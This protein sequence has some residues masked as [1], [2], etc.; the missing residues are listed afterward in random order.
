VLHAVAGTSYDFRFVLTNTTTQA[1]GFDH[2]YYLTFLDLDGE[3][4]PDGTGIDKAF[5]EGVGVV[6]ATEAI[7]YPSGGSVE[8]IVTGVS[9]PSGAYYGLRNVTQ[10]VT[11]DFDVNAINTDIPSGWYSGVVGFKV[12]LQGASNKAPS[13]LTVI[14][15]GKHGGD[16]VHDG[17]FCFAPVFPRPGLGCP[18]PA[19]PAQ[20]LASPPSPPAQP[21]GTLPPPSPPPPLPSPPPPTAPLPSPP[22][23]LPS[24]PPPSLPLPSP[25][26]PLPSPPPPT[27]APPLDPPPVPSTPALASPSPLAPPFA[28]GLAP[29]Y[30]PCGEAVVTMDLAEVTNP[31]IYMDWSNALGDEFTGMKNPANGFTAITTGTTDQT[32]GAFPGGSVRF[33]NAAT[34]STRPAIA[35][36]APHTHASAW[37]PHTTARVTRPCPARLHRAPATTGS[38]STC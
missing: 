25:P 32:T 1:G 3:F 10:K 26:P 12:G 11:T 29:L 30:T 15:G 20:P 28:P 14:V 36:T 19:P 18:P 24:P 7:T 37:Y 35:P 34:V 23:P 5:R 31:S 17:G 33:R 38:L 13:Q 6:G 27:P 8:D 2:A 9:L 4:I 16:D 21:V 22:P